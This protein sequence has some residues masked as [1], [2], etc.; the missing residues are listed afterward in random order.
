M[1]RKLKAGGGL[2]AIMWD[3]CL[4]SWERAGDY[5]LRGVF[6]KQRWTLRPQETKESDW[7]KKWEE[8]S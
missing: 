3:P 1:R 8:N 4:G 6:E 7:E 2:K 5:T